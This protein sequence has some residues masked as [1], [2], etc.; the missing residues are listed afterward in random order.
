M[1]LS[2]LILVFATHSLYIPYQ[3]MDTC[4]FAAHRALHN[5]DVIN[6]FCL[7]RD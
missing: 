5:K 3:T 2:V 1:S 4:L 6:A 7:P